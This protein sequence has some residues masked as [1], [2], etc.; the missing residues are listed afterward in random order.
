MDHPFEA[1]RAAI[2]TA[3]VHH[4]E[5]EPSVEALWLQ[6]SLARGDADAFSDIDAYLVVRDTD[7]DAAWGGRAALLD[8]LGGALA[9]ADATTPGLAAVHALMVGGA[10]L[11][12][13]FE[14]ASKS[15][16]A[17]RPVVEP[18]V[19]KSGVVARLRSGWE[20]PTPTVG[21]IVQGIIRLTRQGATWPL[22]A[23]GREL[24]STL[25]MME[26]DLINA[27]LAQL[28]AVRRDPANFYRNVFS[29]PLVL[30]DAERA[31]LETLSADALAALARRDLAALKVVHL[32]V[33]D[34]LVE[35]GRAACAALGVDYPISESGD[36]EVRA[37]LEQAWPAPK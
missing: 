23:I 30:A 1:A 35:A 12:L 14:A 15:S 34:A 6:G 29:L 36:R 33:L 10:R 8:S 2:L 37:L 7:L 32:R 24:W 13:F 25:A 9:W 16:D 4:A 3:L 17:P 26:L 28:M 18:L 31:S 21:R 27:Q 20:A 19:D 11:D 5:L 22:R